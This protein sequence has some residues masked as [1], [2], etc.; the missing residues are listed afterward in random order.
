[1]KFLH[2][3]VLF[4]HSLFHNDPISYL[5]L[6]KQPLQTSLPRCVK[7]K[8]NDDFPS[9]SATDPHWSDSCIGYT[10]ST[11]SRMEYG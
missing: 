2:V 8:L 6:L 11:F 1:M 5:L 10:K 3:F 7:S 9:V 4:N